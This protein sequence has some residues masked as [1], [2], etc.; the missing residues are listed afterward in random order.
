MIPPGSVFVSFVAWILERFGLGFT[1]PAERFVD[2]LD[3]H[4]VT[5]QLQYGRD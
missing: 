5:E 1:L 3:E 4:E 2:N